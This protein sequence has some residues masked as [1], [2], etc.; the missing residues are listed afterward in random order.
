MPMEEN[1]AFA[2][3]QSMLNKNNSLLSSELW[4]F[5]L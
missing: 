5:R 4:V 3:S 1:A 2:C